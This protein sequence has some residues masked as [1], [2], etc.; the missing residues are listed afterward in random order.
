MR[1]LR[2]SRLTPQDSAARVRELALSLTQLHTPP[3]HNLSGTTVSA[4][5]ASN[6]R[7]EHAGL[8]KGC[9]AAEAL[10]ESRASPQVP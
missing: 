6:E 7:R 9:F 5:E 1:L 4:F 2:A 3:V 10:G 8:D